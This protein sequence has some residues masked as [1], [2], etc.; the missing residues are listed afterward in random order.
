MV[1]F[2]VVA[3][4]VFCG[5]VAV[6]V[7]TVVVTSVLIVTVGGNAAVVIVRKFLACIT[8]DL[9]GDVSIVDAAELR[10]FVADG[11]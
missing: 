1:C 5:V 2:L 11:R 3:A 7:P 8:W 4:V 9:E 10:N 6:I